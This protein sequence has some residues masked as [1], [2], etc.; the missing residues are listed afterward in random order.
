MPDTISPPGQNTAENTTENITENITQPEVSLNKREPNGAEMPAPMGEASEPTPEDGGARKLGSLTISRKLLLIAAVSIIPVCVL[1]FFFINN[2]NQQI[3]F[4][5]EKLKGVEYVEP[6]EGLIQTVPLHR[7]LSIRILNG[8]TSVVEQRDAAAAQVDSYIATLEQID[9]KYGDDFGTTPYLNELTETWR[10]LEARVLTATPGDTFDSHSNL[11]GI[12]AFALVQQVSDQSGLVLDTNLGDS[13]TAKLSLETLPS[14]VQSLSQLRDLGV[15]ILTREAITPR[16]QGLMNNLMAQVEANVAEA[17]RDFDI[18]R[19][20]TD[21]GALVELEEAFVEFEELAG[22]SVAMA[23]YNLVER[24]NLDLTVDY[25]FTQSTRSVIQAFTLFGGS[26]DGLVQDLNATADSLKRSRA[27]AVGLVLV[28]LALVALL[29]LWVSRL[30]TR[31]VNSLATVARKVG[32]G[33]LST[34]ADVDTKD[35]LGVLADA[36]NQAIVALR[37]V[38]AKNELERQNNERLQANVAQFL[39]VAMDIADGDLTKRGKVSE[40]VLGNV[41]DAINLMVEELG[42]VLS[43]VKAATG[44]VTEGATNMLGTSDQIAQSALQQ[45]DEAQKAREEVLAITQAIGEMAATATTSASAAEQALLASEQ[46]QAAVSETLDGMQGIRREVQAVAKRIKGLGDRSLEISEIVET[47]SRISKQT[48]LLAL[49]AAIEASGAGEAGNRFSVVAEEV[50][51]L[52][53][54]SAEATE[55]VAALIKNVQLEVQEVIVGVEEGTREVEAGYRVA[56]QAGQRLSE[57]TEI[58]KQSAQFAQRISQTTQAQVLRVEQVGA[59]VDEMAGISQ[60]SRQTVLQSREA[61]EK[62]QAL[63]QQ[64][65]ENIARFRVA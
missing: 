27:I 34:F 22:F 13:Y 44:S 58:S 61:A 49:N 15:G 2:E 10:D 36:F 30:I 38:E 7:N 45:A 28:G 52:A 11:I 21:E 24:L 60:R 51:K 4:V 17:R 65:D 47:I 55:R 42:F 37:E 57:I 29:Y 25:Y 48:N 18:V 14:T 19:A 41:I 62:L 35:E 3:A 64:L 6:L 40:D 16:E 26:L 8:D 53:D 63:A 12:A 20:N 31:P 43:D 46:G 56:S 39:D 33:D 54:S 32:R 50:R 1:L 5:N 9:A 59:V 23:R